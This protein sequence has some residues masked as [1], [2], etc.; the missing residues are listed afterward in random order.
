MESKYTKLASN[1]VLF[2]IGNFGSKLI[3]FVMLPLY[4]AKLSTADFGTSDLLLTT[5]S[6]LLPIFSL[7]VG[8]SILRFGLEKSESKKSIFSN[9]LVITAIGVALLIVLFPIFFLLDKKNSLFLILILILQMFQT[10]LS[11]FAKANDQI[12]IFALNGILLSFLTAVCNFILLVPL[13]GGLK[14]YLLSIVIAYFISN[15]WLL[16]KIKAI[17][18]IDFSI[19]SKT[20]IFEM[21][22]YSL[23]LIPNSIALWA[24]NALSRYFILFFIGTAANGLFAV[25]YKIPSMIG[26]LNTIFFQAWQLTVIQEFDSE[27]RD[28]FYSNVFSFYSDFLFLGVSFILVILKPMMNLLVSESFYLAWECVPFLLLTVLYSSFSTFFGNYYAASK[29]TVK[30]MT[31][32]VLG[33]L[34]NIALLFVLIPFLGINGA[35]IASAISFFVIW[36]LRQRDTQRF[37]KTKSNIKKMIFNHTIFFV[38]T[39]LLFVIHNKINL[40]TIESVLFILCLFGNKTLFTSMYSL[41]REKVR[42]K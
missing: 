12:R 3:T 8:D 18:Y 36:I 29:E 27:N 40:L 16:V 34:I 25:A 42:K 22:R 14:G 38:Q 30:V 11:Q 7:S 28:S 41:V 2:A 15:I 31:T 1:S 21:I 23:P 24:T 9:S 10:L 19:V 17:L 37:V 33:S 32:T 39:I 4:T 35:G 26:V 6:L 5:V 13:N 20:K